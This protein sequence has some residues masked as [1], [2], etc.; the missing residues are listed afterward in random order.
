MI[1]ELIDGTFQVSWQYNTEEHSS[2]PEST[3]CVIKELFEEGPQ[4]E[5][6][7][8]VAIVSEKDQFVKNTGRKISLK[9]ALERAFNKETRQIFWNKYAESR[10]GRFD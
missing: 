6:A 1:I 5:I 4:V 10:H 3:T 8:G 2:A 7:R 9:R